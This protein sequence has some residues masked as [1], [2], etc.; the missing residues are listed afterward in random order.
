MFSLIFGTADVIVLCDRK[1][2]HELL[3]KKGSIYSDRP[4]THMSNT[5]GIS[6]NVFPSQMGAVWKEKRK[7]ISHTLSPSQ[8]DNNHWRVQEAE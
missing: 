6:D 2:V 7:I 3:D 8:L 1:A 5:L 4:V